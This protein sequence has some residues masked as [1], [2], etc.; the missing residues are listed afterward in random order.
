MEEKEAEEPDNEP[1]NVEFPLTLR[2]LEV[3]PAVVVVCKLV[4]P[5]TVR[6]LE[7]KEVVVVPWRLDVP[8]TY[9]FFTTPTPPLTYKLPDVVDE[10]WFSLPTSSWAVVDVPIWI[11]LLVPSASESK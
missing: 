3:K 7:L 11:I 6:L 4:D 2:L 8:P 10:L 5:E 1:V 9:K